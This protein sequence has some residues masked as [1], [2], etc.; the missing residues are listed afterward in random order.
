MPRDNFKAANYAMGANLNL[1]GKP[2]AQDKAL[3]LDNITDLWFC[4]V[5][6]LDF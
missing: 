1:V 3:A 6:L 4:A 2:P 5:V